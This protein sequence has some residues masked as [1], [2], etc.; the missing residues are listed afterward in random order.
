[1]TQET[2]NA[3]AA[4][5]KCRHSFQRIEKKRAELE[6]MRPADP[7]SLFCA[8]DHEAQLYETAG[9]FERIIL[10]KEREKTEAG[11]KLRHFQM[12]HGLERPPRQPDTAQ[13]VFIIVLA[14]CLEMGLSAFLL[15]NDGLF[16]VFDA[17]VLALIFGLV[18]TV[19]AL[20]TG[21][22]GWRFAGYRKRALQPESKDRFIRGL[23]IIG[24]LAGI[25]LIGVLQFASGRVRVLGS[26]EGLFDF[27]DV[28][29]AATFDNY[30]A[31]ALM[32]IG[33]FSALI[34]MITAYQGLADC[35]PGYSQIS[36]EIKT[37][38]VTEVEEAHSETVE[39]L[40]EIR[41]GAHHEINALCT[42]GRKAIADY[43]R[44]CTALKKRIAAHNK[45]TERCL[46]H[47]R[48]VQINEQ[49]AAA[50]V[51]QTDVPPQE[52]HLAEFEGLLIDGQPADPLTGLEAKAEELKERIDTA[53]ANARQRSNKA[54]DAYSASLREIHHTSPIYS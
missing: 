10:R 8:S 18:N 42:E 43:R 9:G 5:G 23:A 51:S 45:H 47:W 1:M 27:E 3:E 7:F 24:T 28:S 17:S 4:L 33:C 6:R 22:Y 2:L 36:R 35:Y 37:S 25:G 12:W 53:F 39:T 26:H 41:N 13:A 20:C 38:L 48:S 34:N 40:R 14:T 50:Y 54:M 49:K 32:V 30:L 31:L 11:E 46:T 52:Y 21:L 44:Q 15:I 29:V 16:T 19:T